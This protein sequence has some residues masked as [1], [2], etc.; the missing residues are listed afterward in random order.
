MTIVDVIVLLVRRKRVILLATTVALL[1]GVATSF[2]L[3]VRYMAM[4]K[5]M[6]PRQ[7]PSLA[8]LLIT[9]MGSP[10]AASLAAASGGGL[11]LR[12]PNDLYIGL[13][14][15]RPIAD[16]IIRRFNLLDVYHAKDMT[17]ARKEL[18]WYTSIK[19][20]KSELISISVTDRDKRRATDIANAY[21]EQL[22]ELTQSFAVTEASA[23]RL[24]YE[25]EIKQA[26]DD[27]IAAEYSFRNVEQKEGLVQLDAQA[28][29]LIGNIAELR[30]AI[31]AKQ[32]ELRALSS[33]ST[34]N[35]PEVQLTESQLSSLQG[36]L[37]KLEQRNGQDAGASDAGIGSISA[38]GLAYLRAEHELQY[39]QTL[40]DLLLRQLDAAKL[41]EAKEGYIVQVVE[42][43]IEPDR[44]SFPQR[45][46]VVLL[47]T[48][49]GLIA[50]CLWAIFPWWKSNT[51]PGLHWINFIN[52]VGSKIATADTMAPAEAVLSGD[53][54][55]GRA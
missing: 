12:N 26:N 37:A 11:G 21:A 41:D 43:A 16:A 5:I 15:S 42:P 46:L 4:T 28:K 53:D 45:K 2:V 52:Q 10:G 44:K 55:R 40:F 3:P 32:V 14:S 18:A 24:F 17:A 7:A 54:W 22:F 50:G 49:T 27:L 9:Q 51:E 1:A 23:R 19:T 6:T 8:S 35:N 48:A 30:A 13:L 29:A 39:R 31:A 38:S 47:F 33:Y 20:E 36:Q 34:E 25:K